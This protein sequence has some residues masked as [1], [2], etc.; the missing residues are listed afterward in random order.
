MR[1]A[2]SLAFVWTLLLAIPMTALALGLAAYLTDHLAQ[3]ATSLAELGRATT[4]G[5]RGWAVVLAERWPEVAGM[6]IGQALILTILLLVHKNGEE[7]S[8]S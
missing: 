2:Y 3:I 8:T 6:L 7:R 5:G 4:V 1:K